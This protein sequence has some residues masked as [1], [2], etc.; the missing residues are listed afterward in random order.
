MRPYVYTKQVVKR[1]LNAWD[2]ITGT[3]EPIQMTLPLPAIHH[4][5]T[6]EDYKTNILNAFTHCK[7]CEDSTRII[8]NAMDLD[9]GK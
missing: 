6:V 4:H 8:S 7:Y 3:G 9:V 1:L 5:T 2:N